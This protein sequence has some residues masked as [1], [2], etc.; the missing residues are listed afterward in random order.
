MTP[1]VLQ[2]LRRQEQSAE[3]VEETEASIPGG[4]HQSEKG[5]L[6][7]CTNISPSTTA[8]SSPSLTCQLGLQLVKPGSVP[9]GFLQGSIQL[10]AKVH[11][12]LLVAGQLQLKTGDLSCSRCQ[13]LGNFNLRR[14]Q[15]IRRD[16][17][18]QDDFVIF[19]AFQFSPM[20]DSDDSKHR[21]KKGN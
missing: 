1:E 3:K 17:K 7:C 12:L 2:E 5:T 14:E 6:L 19:T 9:L 16:R 11:L 10:G 13:F 8:S 15:R 18:E 20:W 4:L 21:I